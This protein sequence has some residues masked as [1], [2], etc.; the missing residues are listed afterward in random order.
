MGEAADTTTAESC[1]LRVHYISNYLKKS[2]SHR[3]R[4]ASAFLS[5]REKNTS[6]ECVNFDANRGKFIRITAVSINF[7]K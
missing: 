4:W 7:Y 3:L 2:H 6:G 5:N 1:E